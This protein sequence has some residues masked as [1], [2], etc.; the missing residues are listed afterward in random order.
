MSME[1]LS[2]GNQLKISN[3]MLQRGRDINASTPSET[4]GANSELAKKLEIRRQQSETQS[5]D[6]DMMGTPPHR[7][8][9]PLTTSERAEIKCVCACLHVFL[10]G[11]NL[12]SIDTQSI[13]M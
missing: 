2:A 6:T 8:Q 12:R 3:S 1:E 13:Q 9:Q 11:S 4:A 5:Q 10:C 7:S